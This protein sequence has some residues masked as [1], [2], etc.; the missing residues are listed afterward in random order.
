MN[1]S[2]P[3]SPDID[4]YADN[5]A[6]AGETLTYPMHIA[7]EAIHYLL[8]HRPPM[9]FVKD[10]RVLEYN[11]YI[12]IASW[13]ADTPVV[14]GHF[15]GCPLIPGVFLLEAAAQVAGVGLLAGDPVS[16]A[17]AHGRL[18]MLAGVRKCTFRRPVMP[19][20]PVTYELH[21]RRVDT[22]LA[23]VTGTAEVESQLVAQLEFMVAHV[24]VAALAALLPAEKLV[25]SNRDVF[26]LGNI[27]CASW[28]AGRK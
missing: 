2:M 5:S 25:E 1:S 7:G 22:S 4:D 14:D 24:E 23:V 11:H 12:G 19:N 6:Q 10:V 28:S 21:A 17:A 8:P 26:G 16:R 9:L 27:D 15:R 3:S 18:G 20:E 13:P